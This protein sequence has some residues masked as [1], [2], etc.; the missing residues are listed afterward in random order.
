MIIRLESITTKKLL[1]CARRILDNKGLE[2]FWGPRFQCLHQLHHCLHSPLQ[3]SGFCSV[4]KKTWK[5]GQ[6]QTL[7]GKIQ[8]YLVTLFDSS[9]E[10]VRDKMVIQGDSILNTLKF[11]AKTRQSLELWVL[12]LT[13]AWHVL[14]RSVLDDGRLI[15]FTDGQNSLLTTSVW[16]IQAIFVAIDRNGSRTVIYITGCNGIGSSDLVVC[17]DR[18]VVCAKKGWERENT[19]WW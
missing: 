1:T 19:E 12:V 15:V 2:L 18:V 5:L 4:L 14:V 3:R 9:K 16:C 11:E 10:K 6:T 8:S 13:N 17:S 7:A